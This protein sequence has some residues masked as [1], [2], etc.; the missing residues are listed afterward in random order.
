MPKVTIHVPEEIHERMERE[1]ARRRMT[2]SGLYVEGAKAVLAD[3]GERSEFRRRVEKA[4]QSEGFKRY[5]E[6][7]LAM[8][9]ATRARYPLPSPD[10]TFEPPEH[11]KH[12]R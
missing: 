4:M 8:H 10:E 5:Q 12:L 1:V 3:G 2:R 7:S 9:E 11:L 6:E